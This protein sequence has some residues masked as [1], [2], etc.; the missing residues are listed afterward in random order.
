VADQAFTVEDYGNC[1]QEAVGMGAVENP[2]VEDVGIAASLAPSDA[3]AG[4]DLIAQLMATLS[5]ADAGTGLE[6]VDKFTIYL[7]VDPSGTLQPLGIIVL[8]DSRH[9]LLPGTRDYSEAV[10]GRH[11]EIDFGVEFLPRYLELRVSTVNFEPAQRGALKRRLAEY[12]NPL[13]GPVNLVFWDEPDREYRVRY[14]GKLDITRHYANWLEFTIPLKMG[15]P[16]IVRMWEK[17]HVGSGTLVNEGTFE[18]PL[19]IEIKGPVTNPTVT[20][21]SSVLG[22]TGSLTS[23]DTLVIDTGAMTVTFNGQN[24]LANYSGGFP[25]LPPGETQVTAAASGTTTFR[26][27]E[28]WL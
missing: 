8:R 14:S 25:K 19:I 2:G 26:W 27:R 13:V 4:T 9:E 20:V 10:P 24:A 17:T 3:G 16:F 18:A 6:D 23:A 22:Y 5:T 15:D 28:R 1:R 7:Y 12:L 11:G 21:G